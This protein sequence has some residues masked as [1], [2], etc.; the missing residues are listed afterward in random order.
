MLCQIYGGKNMK[1]NRLIGLMATILVALLCSGEAK[2][3]CQAECPFYAGCFG[4]CAIDAGVGSGC[5]TLCTANCGAAHCALVGNPECSESYD[6]PCDRGPAKRVHERPSPI[7][8]R[9]A[10]FEIDDTGPFSGAARGV[11]AASTV[12]YGQAALAD[13][14]QRENQRRQTVGPDKKQLTPRVRTVL[15]VKPVGNEHL[16]GP[17]VSLLDAEASPLAPPGSAYY[18][19]AATDGRGQVVLLESLLATLP[20]TEPVFENFVREQ[21]LVDSGSAGEPVF[22]FGSIRLTSTGHMIRGVAG[23]T[24]ILPADLVKFEALLKQKK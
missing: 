5:G 14:W 4:Y 15:H 8:S 24:P 9:W 18:F 17:Q 20:G 2:A 1:R 23:L 12:E 22:F 16:V 13:Y 21:F 11:L 3:Y 6:T 10:V 19:R 7:E